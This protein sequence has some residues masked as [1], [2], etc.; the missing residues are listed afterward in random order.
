[1]L[2]R[3]RKPDGGL[4]FVE[5][6]KK[7]HAIFKQQSEPHGIKNKGVE[8]AEESEGQEVMPK[9]RRK[10]AKAAETV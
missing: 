3:E 10:A 1:M 9:Q 4:L 5:K 2:F 8:G 6:R 7:S